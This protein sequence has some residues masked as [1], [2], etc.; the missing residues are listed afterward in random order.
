MQRRKKT[1]QQQQ[2]VHEKWQEK[3]LPPNGKEE[4]ETKMSTKGGRQKKI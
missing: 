3:D 1:E 4:N 2:P